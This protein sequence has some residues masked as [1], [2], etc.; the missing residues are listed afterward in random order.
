MSRQVTDEDMAQFAALGYPAQVRAAGDVEP[1]TLVESL[2]HVLES[3][4]A[5]L[6]EAAVLAVRWL[7]NHDELGLLHE[8]DLSSEATRRLGFLADKLARVDALDR[9]SRHRLRTLASSLHQNVTTYDPPLTFN[10]VVT[11]TYLERLR[12]SSD[13]TSRKWQVFADFN[14]GKGVSAIQ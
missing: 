5:R 11:D 9:E 10:A 14:P 7:A 3:P 8:A 12:E 2:R 1:E 6:F 4:S 13:D